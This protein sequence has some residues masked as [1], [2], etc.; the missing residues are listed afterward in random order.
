MFVLV[1][2]L[3]AVS[4]IAVWFAIGV[5]AHGLLWASFLH[6]E[7]ADPFSRIKEGEP[8]WSAYALCLVLCLGIGVL[9]L[10]IGPIILYLT[11]VTGDDFHGLRW[12]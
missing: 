11:I 7:A 6:D 3:I 5:L 8:Y 4:L 2:S 10:G 12:W 1:I 9:C